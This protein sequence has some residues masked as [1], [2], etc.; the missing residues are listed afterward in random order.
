MVLYVEHNHHMSF[1]L[2]VGDDTNSNG[3]YFQVKTTALEEILQDSSAICAWDHA[4]PR[5]STRNRRH[6]M[7]SSSFKTI[8]L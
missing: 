3:Q 6:V 8:Y 1:Q 5:L 2:W 7:S 4:R